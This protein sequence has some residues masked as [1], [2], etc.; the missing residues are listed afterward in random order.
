MATSRKR[1]WPRVE[2]VLSWGTREVPVT[3]RH[4]KTGV[5]LLHRGRVLTR[6]YPSR[7]GTK[8]A[9]LVAE[10][11]GVKL[12]PPGGSV[13]A[14]VSTGVLY[15]AVSIASLDLRRPETLPLVTRLL[16]EADLQRLR[17]GGPEG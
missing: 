16:E 8:A 17:G 14:V 1:A 15:R 9:F 3:L 6:C 11:L 5:A 10:A 2:K 4:G 13:D 7:S 12:P